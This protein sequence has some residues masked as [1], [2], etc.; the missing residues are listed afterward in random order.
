MI[1]III[2]AVCS[3]G[4]CGSLILIMYMYIDKVTV[5]PDKPVIPRQRLCV[6][7]LLALFSRE[8]AS[9]SDT[10]PGG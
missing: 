5:G 10:P 2:M 9:L 6:S 8:Y 7:S 1:Y 4:S 3:Q